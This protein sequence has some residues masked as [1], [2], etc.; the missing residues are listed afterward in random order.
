MTDPPYSYGI[1]GPMKAARTI[2]VESEI[3]ADEVFAHAQAIRP[4]PTAYKVRAVLACNQVDAFRMV[5]C[6]WHS[7]VEARKETIQTLSRR[8][9]RNHL[10]HAHPYLGGAQ[11]RLLLR[12]IQFNFRDI[13]R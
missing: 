13:G 12:V 2:T 5:V 6:D 1:D 10:G 8:A 4:L 11:I 9:L 3:E 7:E